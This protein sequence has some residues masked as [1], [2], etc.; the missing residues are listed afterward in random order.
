ML[1]EIIDKIQQGTNL[2][3]EEMENAFDNIMTGKVEKE[4]LKLFL[5]KLSEKKETIEEITGATNSMK[6]YVSKV[7][8]DNED[9]LDIVGTGG[10]KKNSV[11]VSTASSI[12][13][14]SAG[15][16][17]AKH[18]NRSVSSKSGAADVL[19]ELGVNI[20]LDHEKNEELLN[21]INIAFI[22]ARTHHPAMKY[23]AEARKEL[24][25]KTI[26]NLVG[27]LTNPAFANRMVLG[28]YDKELAKKFANVLAN[29][30]I[31]KALVVNGCDGYDEITICD[32]T[33]VFEVENK[34]VKEYQIDPSELGINL[35]KEEDLVVN[36]AKESAS[37]ILAVFNGEKG[38][39]YDVIALNSAA[40]LYSFGIASSIKEGL[41]IAK[42]AIDNK[43]ALNKL[44]E[45]V[46]ESNN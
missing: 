42:D 5:D 13:C 4:E 46:K 23:A 11:N 25:K 41:E 37:K 36:D 26:F 29:L 31:K 17:V 32:K 21:K 20:N 34:E 14:A 43:K 8:I 1:E 33:N 2:T 45:L 6:K 40:G 16:T 22:F 44:N 30:G 7:S 9:I 19:E 15:A 35:A 27:P 3:K 38:P 39:I 24:G 18:G 10:D 12:V 28:V